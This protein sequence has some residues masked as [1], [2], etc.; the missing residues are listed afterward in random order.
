MVEEKKDANVDASSSEDEDE[1]NKFK[2][3]TFSMTD[4]ELFQACG[5]MTA[6]K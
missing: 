1:D 2:A 5:G 6:H 3:K 4:E